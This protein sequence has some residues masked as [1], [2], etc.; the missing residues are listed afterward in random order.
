M[1]PNKPIRRA[2]CLAVVA[3]LAAM[4]SPCTSA[5]QQTIIVTGNPLGRELAAQ[6]ASVLSGEGLLL[7]RAGTLGETLDGLPGISASYFGPNSSRPVIRGMDGDRVRLLDN[8]GASVDASNLS[9]DHA[10]ASD[11]LITERIEVL[12]GPAALLYGGSATGGVVNSI[13]NRIPRAPAVDLSGRAELRLGGA[14]NE[15]S[16][17]FVLEGGDGR[18]DGGLAWHAD[19]YGHQADDLR[20]PRFT[21]VD[22]GVALDPASRVR[23]SASRGAGGAIGTSWTSERSFV[24]ASLE[25]TRSRYGVTVEPDVTI[26]MQRERAAL[27]GEWRSLPGWISQIAT[28]ASHTRYRHEEIEGS[29]AVGTTFM[30]QGDELRLQAHHAPIGGLQGVFGL[31]A[32]ALDFQA[33]GAEAFVPATKTRSAALFALE[34]KTFGPLVLSAGG[35]IERVGVDSAGDSASDAIVSDEPHFGA[36]TQRRFAPRS[37][38]IGARI[39][40]AQG[41]QLSTSVG[42]TERAPAYYELF[43]DGVHVATASYER[44][45]STLATESSRNAELG[46]AWARRGHSA[47]LNLFDTRFARFISL[48]ATGESHHVPGESGA[49]DSAVPVYAFQSVRART[50]GI[51]LEG[52]TRLVD[53]AWTVDLTGGLDTVRG[54]NLDTGQPLPRL[55]PRRLRIGL[56]AGYEKLRGGVSWRQVARQDRVPNTDTATPGYSMVDLWASGRVALGQETSWFARL[57]N[58]SN[59]LAFNASTIATMRGL[60]PLPGRALTVGLR[61]RF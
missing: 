47:K 44:G 39:G 16:T 34:E 53:Q 15:R 52:R 60:A 54:D 20:V 45:S 41:W 51:E 6:P 8:G 25:T 40:A 33:L 1:V 59:A 23:N 4:T 56:E 50:K 37:F 46:L 10:A 19:A 26:R 2:S 24:G 12:R 5:Q 27:A 22:D 9:F 29:G 57:S 14:A 58:A 49:A 42:H 11:P 17:A 61:S 35:R 21:P 32:E 31:Q 28:Q 13:D 55:A 30:S 7:R 18:A 48:D 38:S 43:A 36:A 3:A